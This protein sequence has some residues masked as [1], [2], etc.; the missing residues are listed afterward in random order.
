MDISKKLDFDSKQTIKID[1]EHEFE[2]D[3][4]ASNVMLMQEKFKNNDETLENLYE[5]IEL[6][7]GK[8]ATD[9]I[10]AKNLTFK[11]LQ[12]VIIAI[13]AAANEMEY[14]EMEKRFQEFKK[15]K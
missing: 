12:I 14:D 1:A 13:M 8:E 15:S 3:C 10:K 9:L 2:V 6:A 11:K 7:M 5:I 4:S